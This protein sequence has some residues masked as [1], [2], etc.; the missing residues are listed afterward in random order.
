MGV[1]PPWDGSSTKALRRLVRF[2]TCVRQGAEA[3]LFIT[4][5]GL[6]SLGCSEGSSGRGIVPPLR[7]WW[8]VPS[9]NNFLKR[10]TL[11]LGL[12][13]LQCL[14]FKKQRRHKPLLFIITKEGA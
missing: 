4:F 9:A 8:P 11:R 1:R 6:R 5:A 7:E 10:D 3:K 14:E 12:G 13:Q 2:V